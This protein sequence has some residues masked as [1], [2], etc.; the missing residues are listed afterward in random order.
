MFKYTNNVQVILSIDVGMQD[1]VDVIGDPDN[2]SYEWMIRTPKGITEHSD[3]A[4]G[5][6]SV[7]LRDGLIAYHGLPTTPL[8]RVVP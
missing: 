5:Q 2:A 1:S 4:Y 3:C 6:V 8:I 7:A